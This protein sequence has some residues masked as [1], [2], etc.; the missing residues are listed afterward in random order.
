MNVRVGYSSVA[1]DSRWPCAWCGE[2][3]TSLVG[4]KTD[5]Y[6]TCEMH[7]VCSASCAARL[8]PYLIETANEEEA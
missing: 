7:A 6:L 4:V 1:R 3:T 2:K 8:V 5:R